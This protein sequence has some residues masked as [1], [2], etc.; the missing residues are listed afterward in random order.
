MHFVNES[1]ISF[2]FSFAKI[3]YIYILDKN[4]NLSMILHFLMSLSNTITMPNFIWFR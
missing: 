4:E 2:T 3:S 1:E